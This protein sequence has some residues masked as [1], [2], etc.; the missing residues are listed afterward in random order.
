ML[1]LM[2]SF[3]SFSTVVDYVMHF[4]VS[5][6][7]ANYERR[8]DINLACFAPKDL[9]ADEVVF[10]DDHAL[11]LNLTF[12]NTKAIQILQPVSSNIILKNKCKF[13]EQN[14][15]IAYVYPKRKNNYY[16]FFFIALDPNK[17]YNLVCKLELQGD[18]DEKTLKPAII[19]NYDWREYLSVFFPLGKFELTP[20]IKFELNNFLKVVPKNKICILYLVGYA[21]STP[22]IKPETLRK[23]KSNRELAYKRVKSVLNYLMS[24]NSFNY[25]PLS[26]KE[27]LKQIGKHE[28]KIK[29]NENKDYP[30][31]PKLENENPEKNIEDI[32]FQK[33]NNTLIENS[34]GQ[35]DLVSISEILKNLSNNLEN[36]IKE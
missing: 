27:L 23:V 19:N 36:K 12:T 11:T 13:Y 34:Q 14:K 26:D 28:Q 32:D 9:E 15:L 5:P 20:K 35:D 7:K 22:I 29:N 3:L 17:K 16:D 21:D 4:K 31:K 24:N 33:E 6:Q 30:E 25:E 18:I 1:F 2:L 8:V 10:V